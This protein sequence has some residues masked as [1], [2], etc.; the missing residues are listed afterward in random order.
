MRGRYQER[1]HLQVQA[2]EARKFSTELT[3]QIDASELENHEHPGLTKGA[4]A[5]RR[6]TRSA[7]KSGRPVALK[8]AEG[9]WRIAPIFLRTESNLRISCEANGIDA[10]LLVQC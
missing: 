9:L 4:V 3:Q 1:V 8:V 6:S 2:Y 7:S 10:A 5:A